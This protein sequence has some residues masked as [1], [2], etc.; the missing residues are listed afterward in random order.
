MVLDVDPLAHGAF[1]GDRNASGYSPPRAMFPRLSALLAAVVLS[2]CAQ[3]PAPGKAACPDAVPW[4]P[5]YRT[6]AAPTRSSTIALSADG[7]TLFV[8]N[9]ET[10]TVSVV[11][12]K[13]RRLL[14]EVLLEGA[15]P[16]YDEVNRRYRPKAQPRSVALSPDG[17]RL[18]VT[19]RASG[20]VYAVDAASGRV[21]AAASGGLEPWGVLVSPDG[22]TLYVTDFA[23]GMLRVLNAADLSAR[24]G[25]SIGAAPREM[26]LSGDG[27]TL[28]VGLFYGGVALVDVG[29][30]APALRQTTRLRPRGPFNQAG[31]L[32]ADDAAGRRL[33]RRVAG[34][35]LHPT[36]GKLWVTHL[37]TDVTRRQPQLDFRNTV[38][39]GMAMLDGTTGDEQS[40]AYPFHMRAR[41]FNGYPLSLGAGPAAVDFDP[42]TGE[43][44]VLEEASEDLVVLQPDGQLVTQ[45]VRPIGGDHLRGLVVSPVVREIYVDAALSGEVTILENRTFKREVARVSRLCSDPVPPR[46]RLGA[47]VF[48]SANQA[49]VPTTGAFWLSC[50]LCHYD[51]RTDGVTWQ[52]AAGPRQT[53]SLA[54]GTKDTG[55]LT[56][57]ARRPSLLRLDVTFNTE[58]GG[59]MQLDDPEGRVLL[60]ALAAYIDE[61]IAPTPLAR[62]PG[63]AARRGEA[64][65]ARASVGCAG[66]HRGPRYT[67]SADGPLH[68]VGTCN[69]ADLPHHDVEGRRR[70]PCLFDTPSLT[71]VGA[72]APYLHDGSAATLR[73]VLTTRNANDRHGRTSQLTPAEL[74]DLVAFLESVR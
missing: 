72:T 2:A 66:C 9:A 24:A 10:D 17:A 26:A 51:G 69:P 4:A 13:Q 73:D 71:G 67:D 55:R 32:V 11:D 3:R 37:L 29:A 28:Y 5:S 20:K 50:E 64:I 63:E 42:A 31:R 70:A 43:G 39:P 48:H 25:L 12:A 23:G 34:L 47:K 58:M 44:F 30:R 7:A 27:A 35:G 49:E 54:G 40:S 52:F 14:G 68:D 41:V 21:S 65:F 57:T 8:V 60:E 18:Y 53:P 1:Y 19:G 15:R 33:P 46:L 59:H 61:A 36:A 38:H 22:G 74:D 45:I 16:A 62:A 56:W 6:T